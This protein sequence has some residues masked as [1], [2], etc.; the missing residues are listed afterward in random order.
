MEWYTNSRRTG[1]IE[2]RSARVIA[3]L[4]SIEISRFSPY[5]M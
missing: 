2:A 3:V 1:G 4:V 5:Q